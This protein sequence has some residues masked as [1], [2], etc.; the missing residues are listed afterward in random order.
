[1]DRACRKR[2]GGEAGHIPPQT[3]ITSPHGGP[4][5][6]IREGS[7]RGRFPGV[8]AQT[9]MLLPSGGMG[10]G[11]W[12]PPAAGAGPGAPAAP[13][14]VGAVTQGARTPGPRGCPLPPPA[15][16]PSAPT[17]PAPARRLP[18]GPGCGRAAARVSPG[19][20]KCRGAGAG[21]PRGGQVARRAGAR[22]PRGRAAAV[23]L[24]WRSPRRACLG[25]ESPA[26][27]GGQRLRPHTRAAPP[28]SVYS[29]SP[30]AAGNPRLPPK[31]TS[32]EWKDFG[33]NPLRSCLRGAVSPNPAP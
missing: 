2:R 25:P 29:G 24:A 12:K 15:P 8:Q 21:A 22:G 28:V 19:T 16:P 17:R 3:K 9:L 27:S 23:A 30:H 32:S 13:P 31:K 10:R 4:P 5:D 14:Q 7:G 33:Q 26:I 18:A 1:M 20:C 6:G 11:A